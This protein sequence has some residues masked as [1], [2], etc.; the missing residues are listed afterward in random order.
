[1][2]L[3]SV[4]FSSHGQTIAV[5][6]GMK[7]WA[8]PY[9]GKIWSCRSLIQTSSSRLPL[10]ECCSHKNLL[11][12]RQANLESFDEGT[13][14]TCASPSDNFGSNLGQ[15]STVICWVEASEW[16]WRQCHPWANHT[17]IHHYILHMPLDIARYCR[18]VQ[19]NHILCVNELIRPAC[20]VMM[21]HL[22]WLSVPSLTDDDGAWGILGLS[23]PKNF[24]SI[25]TRLM[26]IVGYWSSYAGGNFCYACSLHSHV[27][28]NRD[29]AHSILRKGGWT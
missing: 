2:K 7:S 27:W 21:A 19:S 3:A 8:T 6:P 29:D 24:A 11:N 4:P 5:V 13:I 22:W 18:A 12:V 26:F 17:S 14:V 10:W 25:L 23:H 9:N 28:R 15:C 20:S 1:M 16:P